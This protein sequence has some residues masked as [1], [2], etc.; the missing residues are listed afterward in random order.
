[1]SIALFILGIGA[2]FL[3]FFLLVYNKMVMAFLVFAFSI[4]FF[5]AAPLFPLTPPIYSIK[6]SDRVVVV[7][8]RDGL[9]VLRLDS[10][11]APNSG[12]S[13]TIKNG[14][15][16]IPARVVNNLRVGEASWVQNQ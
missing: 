6:N 1:M 10:A 8:S 2:L 15:R 11:D 16:L 12:D 3:G 13:I 14:K 7:T 9:M 5:A 4:I